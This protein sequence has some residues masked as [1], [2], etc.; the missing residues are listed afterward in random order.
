[1]NKFMMLVDFIFGFYQQLLSVIAEHW[2]LS[3]MLLIAIFSL[4]FDLFMT[5]KGSK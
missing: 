1:M 4:V 3:L 5:I 2:L